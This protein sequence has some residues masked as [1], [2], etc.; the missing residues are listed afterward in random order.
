MDV[1]I[2]C[3]A[4][5]VYATAK[6]ISGIVFDLVCLCWPVGPNMGGNMCLFYWN[7]QKMCGMLSA[8]MYII[9]M[10]FLHV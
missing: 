5:N 4:R 7:G 3:S 8:T 6:T 1:N 9:C 2:S 10:V